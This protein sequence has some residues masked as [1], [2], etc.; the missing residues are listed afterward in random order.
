M[1]G[2]QGSISYNSKAGA[3][4]GFI[5]VAG[6]RN[7][8]SIDSGHFV[9]LGNAIADPL[10]AAKLL[11]NREIPFNGFSLSMLQGLN[12]ATVISSINFFTP[13]ATSAPLVT[14]TQKGNGATDM[15]G[16]GGFFETW[17]PVN[18]GMTYPSGFAPGST[19]TMQR[20]AMSYA[21][22][23]SGDDVPLG[24][25]D[26]VLNFGYNI[27]QTGGQLSNADG[28]W[29]LGFET[30]FLNNFGSNQLAFEFHLPEITTF[31]GTVSRVC[32]YY[33]S[34]QTAA[35]AHELQVTSTTW[36]TP[37][38]FSVGF[39]TVD[40]DNITGGVMTVICGTS[41]GIG[42]FAFR[43][44]TTGNLSWIQGNGN[45]ISFNI[46][47]LGDVLLTDSTGTTWLNA[48]EDVPPA[49]ANGTTVVGQVANGFAEQDLSAQLQVNSVTRG[50]LPPRMTTAQ[51]NA[52]V[53]PAEG[54]VVY[55]LTLHKLSLRTVAAWET[56]TSV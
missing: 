32:S 24:M 3:P 35:C 34:K 48:N 18:F 47:G 21:L 31:N 49:P 16:N 11:S 28:S 13:N 4:A 54:L 2:F 55:D 42:K 14:W 30:N 52:I 19:I 20:W 56:V 39:A 15:T 7:G 46:Q 27:N 53:A 5:N 50:F 25:P 41:S 51:K 10:N 33:V 44:P 26:A 17:Q 22:Q 9:V 43:N 37:G 8:T 12:T 38:A 6:A 1:S 36:K 29:R 45:A 23:N 40:G